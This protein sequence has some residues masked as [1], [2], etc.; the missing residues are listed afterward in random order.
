MKLNLPFFKGEGEGGEFLLVYG[1]Y[2][3]GK[4]NFLYYLVVHQ[5]MIFLSPKPILVKINYFRLNI[6]LIDICLT[7]Q[8]R[9]KSL[10]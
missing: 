7:Y 6:C 4:F 10:I 5:V 9:K 3:F 8:Y 2:C 1:P